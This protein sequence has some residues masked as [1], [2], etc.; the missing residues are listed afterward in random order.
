[1][2]HYQK[3]I[4][5]IQE[6]FGYNDDP[7]HIEAYMRLQYGVL[8]HLS[9]NDFRDEVEICHLCIKDGGINSAERLAESY[10]L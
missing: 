1:M 2:T 5:E 7:R 9:I 3:T 6:M 8:D 4:N 10:G